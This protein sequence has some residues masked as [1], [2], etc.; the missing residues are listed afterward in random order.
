MGTGFNAPSHRTR[1]GSDASVESLSG[2]QI[3]EIFSWIPP[4]K[5][6]ASVAFSPLADNQA[7]DFLRS[8]SSDS[9][10]ESI[11]SPCNPFY[12]EESAI[13]KQLAEYFREDPKTWVSILSQNPNE[14]AISKIFLRHLND[15][16]FPDTRI[17]PDSALLDEMLSKYNSIH[18]LLA[19]GIASSS[20]PFPLSVIKRFKDRAKEIKEEELFEDMISLN[21]KNPSLC[22]F[23]ILSY[24]ASTDSG[25]TY[26][27]LD[28]NK[29]LT[30]FC[31]AAIRK[32]ESS[33]RE[34]SIECLAASTE[35]PQ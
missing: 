6:R 2:S 21:E 4:G 35:I 1:F 12:I 34:N 5:E 8:P 17:L 27:V 20:A 7:S 16:R 22:A 26:R 11:D 30:H 14:I 31:Q 33:K 24:Y 18:S 32:I 15:I 10:G 23:I 25:A 9:I 19:Y 29:K 28:R 3:K 13:Q